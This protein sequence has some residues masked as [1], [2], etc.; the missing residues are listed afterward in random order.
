MKN[1]ILILLV[2]SLSLL[3]VS[4][5]RSD[6]KRTDNGAL[7]KFYTINNNNEMPE[8]GDMVV[9]DVTQLSVSFPSET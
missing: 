8:I 6:Y 5:N 1:R 4:C 9:V 2:F 7:M 3:I